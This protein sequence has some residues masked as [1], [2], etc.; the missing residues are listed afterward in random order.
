M[1][2]YCL[3]YK[4]QIGW[5]KATKYCVK[6]NCWAFKILKSH[7][8]LQKLINKNKKLKLCKTKTNK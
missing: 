7:T 3:H 5:K 8:E 6:Q 1:Q 4:E 2:Y